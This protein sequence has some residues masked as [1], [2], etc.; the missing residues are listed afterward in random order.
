MI[1]FPNAKINLGLNV[2]SKRQDGYHNIETIFMPIPLHDAL[3]V[4]ETE[5]SGA[6]HSFS[7]TQTGLPVDAPQENNLVLKAMRLLSAYRLPP[8]EIHL[9]KAIHTGAGLGGGSSDGAFMLKLL[10]DFGKLG[11][12]QADLEAIASKLGADCPF[13]I[14]NTAAFASGTGNV[15]EPVA[16]S[17]K[18]YR[19][20]LVTP[21]V[22]IS[23]AEAYAAVRP[24][25]PSASLKE[26]IRLPVDK[27][28]GLMIN[29]FEESIFAK[30]PSLAAIKQNL[31]AA[32]ATYASMTGSGSS[33]YGLFKIPPSNIQAQNLPEG[34]RW[35]SLA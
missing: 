28:R 29:D 4:T 30:H 8:L 35:L 18:E 24:Q 12:G 10:N 16:L 33:I 7:F 22:A 13:F 32:G 6:G 23:T 21:R 25:E 3:E 26:I 2:V 34:G 1:C 31:Y 17:L 15:F 5:A 9:H 20:Y 14:R 27:W 11:L 19:L